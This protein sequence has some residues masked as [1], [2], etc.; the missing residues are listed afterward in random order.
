MST[1]SELQKKIDTRTA[2]IGVIGLGYVGLPLAHAFH[3]GTGG[4][5]GPGGLR[6]I[7][8][9]IDDAKIKALE[10]G[11]N[12]LPHLG[13]SLTTTLSESDRFEATT[14]FSRLSEADAIAVCVPTP[15]GT[16]H[17]PDL[18][19]VITSAQDIG[20]ALRPGQL[21]LLESTTYPSTT[22]DE[23]APAMMQAAAD[24]GR[25]LELGKD[26]FVAFSPEREDPGRKSHSTS[27]IPKLVGGLDDLSTDLACSIYQCA[28][29]EVVRCSSAEVA[30]SAK[31]LENTFRAVN[32][33]LVNEMKVIL[34][35]M[36][37][38]VWEVIRAASTK[39]FGFMPFFP[40]PGLGG[41]CIPIDP[42]YL[43]WKAREIGRETRF[44][45]LAGQINTQMPEYVVERLTLALND[46]SKAVRGSR[47]LIL[48]LSY[49]PDIADTRESPTFELIQ[50]LTD[51]GADIEYSDPLVP[52]MV[53]VRKHS[54]RMKSIELTPESLKSFD[55]VLIS[56][57]HSAFDYELLAKHARLIID[58][59][60]AM[61]RW[62]N[63]MGDRL[64]RA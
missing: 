5:G 8:F 14:D 45:E 42:F 36:D 62:E 52:E 63:E 25:S 39:P 59:R 27:T 12:Y 33:A 64:V 43:A 19:Y 18:R 57:N 1:A 51:L 30:E 58:T 50:R 10:K 2:T 22:R 11:E 26:V 24:A 4:Q 46:R 3:E 35:D 13:A 23:F 61:R 20:K 49:K 40:G 60:D 6:V 37:I 16:H 21:I 47:V 41:H 9:D 38:D 32:I 28:V 31:I 29:E 53:P 34:H 15:V 56:T 17:E 55:V 7:G 44:I 48:G 54:I